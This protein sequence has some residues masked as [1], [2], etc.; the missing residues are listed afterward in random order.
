MSVSELKAAP[1]DLAVFQSFVNTV[2][3]VHGTELL[4]GPRALASWLSQ[5]GLLGPDAELTPADVERAIRLRQDW[6]ALLLA[7]NGAAMSVAATERLDRVAEQSPLRVRVAPDGESRL[8]AAGEGL[9]RVF[10]RLFAIFYDAR[11]AGTWSRLKG[12]AD[13]ACQAAFHDFSPNRSGVWC[14]MNR[15]GNR[16][17]GRAFRRRAKRW[18]GS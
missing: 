3:R 16:A 6:R 15:C 7:N 18:G 13:P 17:K 9:D 1:G 10:G 8:E 5:A 14:A 2:D 4:T 11:K 12:C